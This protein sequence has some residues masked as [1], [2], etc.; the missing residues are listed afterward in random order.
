MLTTVRLPQAVVDRVPASALPRSSREVLAKTRLT[1]CNPAGRL[2]SPHPCG[3]RENNLTVQALVK[4]LA[5]TKWLQNCLRASLTCLPAAAFAAPAPQWTVQVD[6]LTTALGFAHVQF[7]RAVA[8][9]WSVYAGPHLRLFDS[10]VTE[11]NLRMKG[12]GAEAGLRYYWQGQAPSGPWLLA[13]GVL[14]RVVADSGATALGGYGSA[15]IGY[16]AIFGGR[17][18]LAGGLG[19][20]YLHYTVEGRGPQGLFPAAHS[21]L[22]VAF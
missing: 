22:G 12:F 13:R 17:W 20:Q 2:A 3:S 7:E 1:P 19:L 18:V 16:T 4:H 11:E 21:T 15:L 14:A 8:P 10:L 9:H 6:P 5:R